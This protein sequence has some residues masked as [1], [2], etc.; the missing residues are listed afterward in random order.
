[1]TLALGGHFGQDVAFVHAFTLEP[2]SG[3]LEPL[4]G[5]LMGF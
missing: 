4:S 3:F 2:R 1:M 5:T